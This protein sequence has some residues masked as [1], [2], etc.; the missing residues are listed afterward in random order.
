MI[1]SSVF[2]SDIK[3][4]DVTT[5]EI[6]SLQI[7]LGQE[8]IRKLRKKNAASP[9]SEIAPINFAPEKNIEKIFK[10]DTQSVQKVAAEIL[11]K[12]TINVLEKEVNKDEKSKLENKTSSFNENGFIYRLAFIV[13]RNSFIYSKLSDKKIFSVVK[14]FK[15]FVK[16]W[17]H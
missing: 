3:N 5:R 4:I 2:I 15:L 17:R 8:L 10:I 7:S 12:V 1:D 11:P 13:G 6:N 9:A 14:K 16:F